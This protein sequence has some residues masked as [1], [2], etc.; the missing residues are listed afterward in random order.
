MPCTVRNTRPTA[1]IPA[2]GTTDHRDEG[3]RQDARRAVDREQCRGHQQARQHGKPRRIRLD[4][5]ACL[6]GEDRRAG[7]DQPG[8]VVLWVGCGCMRTQIGLPRVPVGRR[9]YRIRRRATVSASG[10]GRRP[11]KPRRRPGERG[12]R[13]PPCCCSIRCSISPVGSAAR[14]RSH[15]KAGRRTEIAQ[16]VLQR[17][18][19]A[20]AGEPD[21]PRSDR[22]GDI[23]STTGSRDRARNR[24]LRRFRR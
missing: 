5:V 23:G 19:Q 21:R 14:V 17:G 3:Q 13:L 11:A 12:R 15:Q 10:R 2:Q 6:D 9:R 22:S 16:V 7:H 20:R 24:F 4:A 8:R 1:A 18:S